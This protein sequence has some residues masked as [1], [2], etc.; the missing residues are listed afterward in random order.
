MNE[1]DKNSICYICQLSR[2]DC[3][4]KNI[5]FD[6]HVKQEHFVWNYLYFLTYLHINDPNNFNSIENDVWEKLE[7]QD[8]T[9]I[10]IKKDAE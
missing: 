1:T 4:R 9:W 3:L 7:E 6:I 2:D 5:D 10:P 8:I